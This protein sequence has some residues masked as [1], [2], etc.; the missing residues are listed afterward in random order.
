MSK[1]RFVKI[2]TEKG[3]QHAHLKDVKK[4]QIFQL[5]EPDGSPA[6]DK[7]GLASGDLLALGDAQQEGDHWAVKAEVKDDNN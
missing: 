3:W 1:V 4:G 6:P 7:D 2:K 5:F